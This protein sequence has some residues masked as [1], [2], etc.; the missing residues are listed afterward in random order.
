MTGMLTDYP[1]L[2][3]QW[4]PVKNKDISIETIT[5]SSGKK[6]WWLG[7]CGHEWD[8]NITSRCDSGQNCPICSG[9]RV[10]SGINDLATLRPDIASEWHTTKNENLLP[11]SVSVGSAKKVWWLGSC[12]HEWEATIG[13]RTAKGYNCSYCSGRFAISGKTDL[14]TLR[15]DIAAQWHPTNNPTLTP[16]TVTYS[17]GRKVWWMCGKGH[18]WDARIADR[19]KGIGCSICAGQKILTGYNDLATLRPSI[20]AEWNYEK[21]THLPHPSTLSIGSAKVA[22]W[23]CKENHEWEVSIKCRAFHNRKC[24]YCSNQRILSGYNDLAT[25]NPALAAEWHPTLN[26]MPASAV[27]PNANK[28]A[29]WLCASGH[30]YFARIADRN[31][32]KSDC[33][34]CYAARTISN[35]EQEIADYIVNETGLKIKQSDR[36]I[37]KPLELDIYIPNK[38]LAIEFNGVYWHSEAVGKGKM[39]HQAKWLAC[40]QQGIELLQVWCEDYEQKPDLI[41]RLIL[42]KLVA[43]KDATPLIQNAAMV[44]VSESVAKTFFDKTS[45]SRFESAEH[46]FG[47]QS[48]KSK[49]LMGLLSVNTEDQTDGLHVEVVQFS[50]SISGRGLLRT[51]VNHIEDR[52]APMTM[53]ASLDNCFAEF[54]SFESCGFKQKEVLAPDFVYLKSGNRIQQ[55]EYDIERF[56]EDPQLLFEDGKSL[57]ELADLNGL[58]RLWDAG[59]TVMERCSSSSL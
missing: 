10:V 12:G 49:K 51:L 47:V 37:L 31:F 1:H 17:S 18:E 59:R 3:E 32:N 40:Q 36:T 25:K 29:W 41:K 42:N 44:E 38:K 45:I 46:Y 39:Y 26:D 58:N 56:R 34:K 35:P 53:T 54:T 27:A 43:T 30:E 55:S 33:P 50:A 9:K 2:V 7:P 16:Q 8:M 52:F 22:W 6:V 28:Q 21:N 15:P 20:A 19:V 48:E 57:T 23:K 14:A 13:G 24:P 11:S 5:K 4:H